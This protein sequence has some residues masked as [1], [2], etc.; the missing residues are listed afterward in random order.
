MTYEINSKLYQ[1]YIR[2]IDKQK[3]MC[4]WDSGLGASEEALV[5][6]YIAAHPL[7]SAHKYGVDFQASDVFDEDTCWEDWIKDV[8]DYITTHQIE[9]VCVSPNCPQLSPLDFNYSS[10]NN[11]ALANL[12][13]QLPR[14]AKHMETTGYTSFSQFNFNEGGVM[15]SWLSDDHYDYAFERSTGGIFRDG[16]AEGNVFTNPELMLCDGI[17]KPDFEYSNRRV[18]IPYLSD[19]VTFKTNS[20][21][22]Q[23]LPRW[24]IGWK[25]IHSSQPTITSTDITNMVNAGK[26]GEKSLKDHSK[27]SPITVTLR[28]RN[29]SM[30]PSQGVQ[31]AA[32]LEGGLGYE[33][34]KFGIDVDYSND[35]LDGR[36]DAL[37]AQSG[38][39]AYFKKQTPVANNTSSKFTYSFERVADEATPP[40]NS[41]T[42]RYFDDFDADAG[43]QG[44]TFTAHNGATFPIDTFFHYNLMGNFN[45]GNSGAFYDSSN[46]STQAFN[47]L[48][49]GAVFESTSHGHKISPWAIKNGA[50]VA[51]GS[52]PEPYADSVD[53]Y[54]ETIYE[55]V[56]GNSYAVAHLLTVA[57]GRSIEEL[58]GDGLAS[59]FKK[60]SNSRKGSNS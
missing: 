40:T 30:N 53:M 55:I 39:Y 12:F 38:K 9:A 2:N 37:D 51:F 42:L 10:T 28:N 43:N 25:K 47:I 8:S 32:F 11:V 23:A 49:G 4:I 27:V 52:Y 1:R 3:V 26:V 7:N 31:V 34:F 35:L 21:L 58:W 16:L 15:Y 33:Q 54:N 24:R 57:G 41:T 59:P 29:N 60:Q 18:K 45:T 22:I 56:S 46:T 17:A 20:Y 5:D 6:A 50:S 14:I 44:I 48:D 19:K 13:G 36:L